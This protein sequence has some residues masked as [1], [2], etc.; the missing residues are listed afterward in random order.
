MATRAA[1]QTAGDTL[2]GGK[3]GGRPA[4]AAEPP[5]EVDDRPVLLA[6]GASCVTPP[7][8]MNLLRL[9]EGSTAMFPGQY[10]ALDL[11]L[12]AAQT[13]ETRLAAE[14]RSLRASAEER[15]LAWPVVVAA[16][17]GLVVGGAGALYLTSR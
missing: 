6:N 10:E 1:A 3:G 11:A 14:N 8:R 13:A 9:P 4:L 12:K 16:A 15:G 7:P 17:L 5:A 2:S